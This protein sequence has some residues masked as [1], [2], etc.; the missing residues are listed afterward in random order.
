MS[1]IFFF[2]IIYR[3]PAL[4]SRKFRTL[5]PSIFL[6][7][8]LRLLPC[9]RFACCFVISPKRNRG[10]GSLATQSSGAKVWE[11]GK[12]TNIDRFTQ[13][14]RN[15]RNSSIDHDKPTQ[16]LA[17]VVVHVQSSTYKVGSLSQVQDQVQCQDLK[18]KI[19]FCD[20]IESFVMVGA[21]K[22]RET[23]VIWV[24]NPKKWV[25][26]P[27][28]WSKPRGRWAGQAPQP[29]KSY[30][31]DRESNKL[32]GASPEKQDQIR[33]AGALSCLPAPRNWVKWDDRTQ[34][35]A[36]ELIEG[37][38]KKWTFL[39][40]VKSF[41]QKNHVLKKVKKWVIFTKKW[42]WLLKK[43]L[44]T[45]EKSFAKHVFSLLH[46]WTFFSNHVS[47]CSKT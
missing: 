42:V 24:R 4:F 21:G 9:G 19:M 45:R 8:A 23:R 10:L 30:G 13:H 12:A 27:Q 28:I 15:S 29:F 44:R 34:K 43:Y 18:F 14:L 11:R 36:L 33:G 32:N 7:K 35:S 41:D 46:E 5:S 22:I 20:L 47:S 26:F 1:N 2:N 17:H 25:H 31:S 38:V 6:K 3:S 39:Q 37:K 40:K 16:S